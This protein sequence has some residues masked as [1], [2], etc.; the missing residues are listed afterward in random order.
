MDFFSWNMDCMGYVFACASWRM[1]YKDC[2][3]YH[4][5]Y[6]DWQLERHPKKI[7]GQAMKEKY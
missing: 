1:D 5:D 2:V 7:K 4:M 6:T 3:S